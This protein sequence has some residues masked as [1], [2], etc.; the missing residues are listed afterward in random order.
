MQSGAKRQKLLRVTVDCT[1]DI[2]KQWNA[3]LV[4]YPD[5]KRQRFQ[6][7]H[8]REDYDRLVKL[9]RDSGSTCRIAFEPTGV[10]HRT[11]ACRLLR[12]G[13]EVCQV[14]VVAAAR[15][16]ERLLR[17]AID[18]TKRPKLFG[19]DKSG[20]ATLGWGRTPLMD[21]GMWTG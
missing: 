12:E 21:R 3:A 10:Y 17:P 8:A 11:L 1:V 4:E 13:F 19:A 7:W 9:L 14:S 5:G 20:E 16:R 6:F 15:Y 18:G 2:A